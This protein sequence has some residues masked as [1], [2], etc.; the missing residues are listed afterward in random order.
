MEL[1]VNGNSPATIAPGSSPS[2]AWSSTNAVSCSASG[3]TGDDGWGGGLATA[4]SGTVV[5]PIN[6]PGI[7]S[8]TLTCAGPG[9][10]GASTVQVT[11]IASATADCGLPALPTT[12][13][14]SPT[15]T[16][17]SEVD[18]FCIGCGVFGQGNLIASTPSGPA[19]ITV[20]AGV[21]GEVT[22]GVTDGSASYPAG[23]QVGFTLAN[24]N[25]LLS[26]SLL[27]GVV[28]RTYLKGSLQ[29]TAVSTA[30]PG[31]SV[32]T[33]QAL[34]V[35]SVNAYGGFAGFTTTKPFDS[36][37]VTVGQLVGVLNV[38]DVYRACVSLQ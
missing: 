15:A 26:L 22:L 34:G 8:Y 27:Q 19:V 28:I 11:V 20:V 18:S 29:D 17:F 36:V 12:A 1:T 38:V 33:L 24:G 9:G 2:F 21:G 35:L 6:T 37:S 30:T 23:R 4:S 14:L 10:S 3:G 16:A 25:T 13:L 32:L 7:Y 31:D 5:G